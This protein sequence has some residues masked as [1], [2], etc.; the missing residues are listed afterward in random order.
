MIPVIFALAPVFAT[1]ALGHMLKRID[2][3]PAGSWAAF[4]RTN[5]FVFFPA[6]L[7]HSVGTTDFSG[8]LIVRVGVV[9]LAIIAVM[10]ISLLAVRRLMPISG[11]SFASIFQC[12]VRW[13][14]F[15][16]L[17]A[18]RPLVGDEGFAIV[19]LGIAVMVPTIN[20]LCVIVLAHG[21]G[22]ATPSRL[23][24]LVVTNPLILGCATGIFLNAT[25]IG[26]PGPTADFTQLLGRGAL[27]LGLLSVGAALDFQAVAQAG[28]SVA[29]GTGM[30]L[31][32]KPA[33]AFGI[34]TWAG[35]QGTELAA[36]MLITSVPTAT[37]GYVLAR[38]LGGDAPL[39]AGLVTSTSLMAMVT[40]PIW[41]ALVH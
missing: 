2:F 34:A 20:V 25:G 19:A 13:N 15:V 8:D 36:V 9:L 30:K 39:M 29:F 22:A 32:V 37:S 24:R 40:M 31:I 28:W 21:S 3:L 18:A 35:L 41:L 11:A 14:G 1:I 6:L 23:L 5:Y 7:I 17:A 38:Q 12:A 33:V 16:A 4:D 27:A 10:T 26:L